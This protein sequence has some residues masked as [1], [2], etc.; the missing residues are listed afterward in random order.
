MIELDD[1]SSD[2]KGIYGSK[3]Q[4]SSSR[5]SRDFACEMFKLPELYLSIKK[6]PKQ[7]SVFLHTQKSNN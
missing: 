2:V 1:C 5:L 4:G 3:R 7:N 6:K